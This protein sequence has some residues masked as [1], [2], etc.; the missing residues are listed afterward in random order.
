MARWFQET[1]EGAGRKGV[2]ILTAK[3]VTLFGSHSVIHILCLTMQSGTQ[4]SPCP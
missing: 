1:A 3:Q 2:V 4:E